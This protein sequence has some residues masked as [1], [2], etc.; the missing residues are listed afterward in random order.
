MFFKSYLYQTFF[1]NVFS[2]SYLLPVLH[3]TKCGALRDLVA[4]VQFKKRNVYRCS[5]FSRFLPFKIVCMIIQ[6]NLEVCS[7]KTIV[8][9][10][11]NVSAIFEKELCSSIYVFFSVVLFQSL[12]SIEQ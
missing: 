1:L 10:F 5:F 12:D 8:T 3:F 4:F 7:L 2:N 6:I 9:F 11:V